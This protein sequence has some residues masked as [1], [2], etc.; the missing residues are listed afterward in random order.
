MQALIQPYER[1]AKV[2]AGLAPVVDLALRLAVAA[3]LGTAVEL[4]LPV[5]LALGLLGRLSALGL[6]L[7]NIVAV[8]SYPDLSDGG[9]QFHILWGLMLAVIVT[10]G[11]GCLALD[12]MLGRLLGRRLPDPTGQGV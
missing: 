7:F 4:S 6:F 5:L 8:I 2:L 1:L 12:P 3:Y 9:L 11:P 10:R